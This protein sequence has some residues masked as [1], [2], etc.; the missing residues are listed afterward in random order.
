MKRNILILT[1]LLTG[2][3]AVEAQIEERAGVTDTVA[4]NNAAT[5]IKA[6]TLAGR[7]TDG[8]L[9]EIPSRLCFCSDR[10]ARILWTAKPSNIWTRPSASSAR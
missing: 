9:S 3:T 7:V 4:P 6:T 5:H 8:H 1:L 10:S 2:C